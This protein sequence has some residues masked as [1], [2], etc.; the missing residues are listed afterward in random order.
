M[1]T[2]FQNQS[3]GCESDGVCMEVPEITEFGIGLI[4]ALGIKKSFLEKM[5]SYCSGAENQD[6][7]G[8]VFVSCFRRYFMEA[9]DSP[10]GRSG[11]SY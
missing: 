6:E 7:Y 3:N 8:R 1:S 4:T 5:R 10:Y 11:Y 9:I 2:L